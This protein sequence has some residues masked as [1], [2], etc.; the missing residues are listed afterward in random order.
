MT[1]VINQAINGSF[2]KPTDTGGW[3]HFDSPVILGGRTELWHTRLVLVKA[4]PTVRAIWSL[5]QEMNS[6]E[7]LDVDAL[8]FRTSLGAIVKIL[9]LVTP[10][11]QA[12]RAGRYEP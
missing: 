8:L 3:T 4:E 10:N 6:L 2:A 5:G 11:P 7:V 12:R 9:K 1:V